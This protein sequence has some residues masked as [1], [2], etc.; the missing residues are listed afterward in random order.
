MDPC[1]FGMQAYPLVVAQHH[2]HRS[3]QVMSEFDSLVCQRKQAE[4][5]ANE[6]IGLAVFLL[7]SGWCQ[8]SLM[9][10][11]NVRTLLLLRLCEKAL[12]ASRRSALQLWRRKSLLKRSL[13]EM[14]GPDFERELKATRLSPRIISPRSRKF[15]PRQAER[16]AE[17]VRA[18]QASCEALKKKLEEAKASIKQQEEDRCARL[19]EARRLRRLEDDALREV[20]SLRLKL[21]KL[22]AQMTG[23]IGALTK[24]SDSHRPRPPE[25]DDNNERPLVDLS[26]LLA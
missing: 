2:P 17:V 3:D 23:K 5:H 11:P 19:E 26:D 14:F 8:S 1:G 4:K 24:N 18:S 6:A 13:A 9:N 12:Q 10:L 20:E 16:K 25:D 15:S 22:N 7:E 21:S